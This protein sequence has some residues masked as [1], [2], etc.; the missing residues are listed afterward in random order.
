VYPEELFELGAVVERR[1][2]HG[3]AKQVLGTLPPL[4]DDRGFK[5]A[6]VSARAKQREPGEQQ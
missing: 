3:E 5:P 1:N 6:C 2:M 4:L